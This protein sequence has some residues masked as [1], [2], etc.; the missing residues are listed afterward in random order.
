MDL[1][2]FGNVT[3]LQDCIDTCAQYAWRARANF[4]NFYCS[5]AVWTSSHSVPGD[6][7]AP[8][9]ACF[10]KAG[11]SQSTQ[12]ISDQYPGYDGIL[13]LYT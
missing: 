13:L 12:N 6:A 5:G 10:L 8:A 2:D 4:V 3:S 9:D 7:Y 11:V 1:Q